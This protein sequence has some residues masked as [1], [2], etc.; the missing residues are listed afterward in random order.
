MAAIKR[1]LKDHFFIKM[2][3]VNECRLFSVKDTQAIALIPYRIIILCFLYFLNFHAFLA[4]GQSTIHFKSSQLEEERD[5]SMLMVE[6][7]GNYL[8]RETKNVIKNRLGHWNV[9]FADKKSYHQSIEPKR[10]TL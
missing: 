10:K 4:F 8:D 1:F 6:G 3:C 5:L 7:I 9:D 2:N